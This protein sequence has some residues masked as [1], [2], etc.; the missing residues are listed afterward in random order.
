[1]TQPHNPQKSLRNFIDSTSQVISCE[2]L[3]TCNINAL[4]TL[5]H[6]INDYDEEMRTFIIDVF[7]SHCSDGCDYPYTFIDSKK[8]LAFLAF[9]HR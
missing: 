1:M 5:H 8:Y 6:N 4:E 9:Y 7:N 3:A 2:E